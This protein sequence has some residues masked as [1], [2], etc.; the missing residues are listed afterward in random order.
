M[1]WSKTYT[2]LWAQ[3]YENNFNDPHK[4]IEILEGCDKEQSQEPR[5]GIDTSR[6]K[7]QPNNMFQK[8]ALLTDTP[9]L[10]PTCRDCH[11]FNKYVVRL[12]LSY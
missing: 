11:P 2:L 12:P 3:A 1:S 10:D 8:L 5:E 4:K 9:N 6:K 7:R